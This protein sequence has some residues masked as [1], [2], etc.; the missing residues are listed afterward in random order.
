VSNIDECEEEDDSSDTVDDVK[1]EEGQGIAAVPLSI[2]SI[3]SV[4]NE[5]ESQSATEVN[6]GE[7][8]A[9]LLKSF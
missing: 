6:Q 2:T 7:E 4:G 5:L 3:L 8:K 9:R 1:T